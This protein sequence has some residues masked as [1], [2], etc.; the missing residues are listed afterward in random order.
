MDV[1]STIS[2][3]M[4]IPD[5]KATIWT[6]TDSNSIVETSN[7]RWFSDSLHFLAQAFREWSHQQCSSAC[8][9]ILT[10]EYKT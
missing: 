1:E 4:H 6:M 9:L 7:F 8:A 10:A 5:L 3:L 2:R